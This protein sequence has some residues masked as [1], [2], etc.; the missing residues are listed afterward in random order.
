MQRVV[1]RGCPEGKRLL[2]SLDTLLLVDWDLFHLGFI[3]L[4]LLPL[5]VAERRGLQSCSSLLCIAA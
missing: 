2:S 5:E 3:S 4:L 1:H